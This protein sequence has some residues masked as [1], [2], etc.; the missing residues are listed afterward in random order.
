MFIGGKIKE[1]EVLPDKRR[2]TLVTHVIRACLGEIDIDH[3]MRSEWVQVKP[4]TFIDRKL[5][6]KYMS[7]ARNVTVRDFKTRKGID[8]PE[9]IKRLR[10]SNSNAVK[11]SCEELFRHGFITSYTIRPDGYIHVNWFNG[12]IEMER[13]T[14]HNIVIDTEPMPMSDA[15]RKLEYARD[16]ASWGINDYLKLIVKA[17]EI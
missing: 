8:A 11:R 16:R 7:N 2:D 4:R 1:I 13:D 6:N 17:R 9:K 15:Q 10:K 5:Y 12:Y 3:E 14:F